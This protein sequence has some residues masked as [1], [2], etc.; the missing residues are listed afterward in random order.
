MA[1]SL[2]IT[3]KDYEGLV[4]THDGRLRVDLTDG[5]L[6]RLAGVIRQFELS[7]RDPEQRAAWLRSIT[8]VELVELATGRWGGPEQDVQD[9]AIR[10]LQ[11]LTE[12]LRPTVEVLRDAGLLDQAVEQPAAVAQTSGREA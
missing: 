5:G 12:K 4:V 8:D 3:P 2:H 7:K 1:T 6:G 10:R 9:E 11:A